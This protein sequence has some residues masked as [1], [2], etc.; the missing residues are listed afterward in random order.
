MRR[1]IL[2]LI[3]G[4]LMVFIGLYMILRPS[5][6]LTVVIS[7]FGVYE[8]IDGVK[9]LI[10]VY[11]LREAFGSFV[12]S[13]SFGKSLVSMIAGLAVIIIAIIAPNLIPTVIVYIIVAAFLF[14]G[15]V[16]IVDLLAL[17]KNDIPT[18]TLGLEAVLS[19]VFA[20]ILFLFPNFLT[21]I[22]MTVFAAILFASGIVM[23]YGSIVAMLHARKIR[24]LMENSSVNSFQ[25]VD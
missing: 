16:S 22:V 9:T 6:F 5:G 12:R 21:G 25:D 10:A 24:K 19:F 11:K 15:L 3:S 20:L 23:I 7:A 1:I 2:L 13:I 17:S 14:S 4:A 8:V 18:G